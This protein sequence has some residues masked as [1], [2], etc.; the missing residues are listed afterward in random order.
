MAGLH[1]SIRVGTLGGHLLL[2]LLAARLQLPH[3]PRCPPHRVPGLSRLLLLLLHPLL[4][5]VVYLAEPVPLGYD[6]GELLAERRHHSAVPGGLLEQRYLRPL[7]LHLPLRLDHRGGGRLGLLLALAQL[8]R[9]P[10]VGLAQPL[11]LG[12]G[13]VALCYGAGGLRLEEAQLL[14]AGAAPLELRLPLVLHGPLDL[15][16]FEDLV[17]QLPPPLFEAEARALPAVQVHLQAL[18][19]VAQ[20]RRGRGPHVADAKGLDVLLQGLGLRLVP[21]PLPPR[22]R[23]LLLQPGEGGTA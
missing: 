3:P 18:D 9:E 4:H 13:L 1:L 11:D 7:R 17:L 21:V 10:R 2:Q 23:K 14:L 5:L 19:A 15:L 22:I 12:R 16:V 6:V 20:H 8:P